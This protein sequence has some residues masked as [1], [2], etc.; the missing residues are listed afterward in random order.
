MQR[1]KIAVITGT[2]AEY[3]LFKPILKSVVEHSALKL[4]LIVTGMHV[5]EDFGYT[6]KEIEKD[7]F[8]IDAVLDTL[9]QEDTCSAMA[10]YIAKCIS[11]FSEEL[12]R[13]KPDILLLLGDRGEMLA[14]AIAATCMNVLIAHI[15]G[16]EVSGSVDEPFR[17]AITKLA[18]L[19]LVATEESAKRVISMGEKPSKV[20]VVGAPGL[21]D[22]FDNLMDPEKLAEKFSL[23]LKKPIILVVQHPVVTE[24]DDAPQQI[25]ETLDTIVELEHQVMLIYPNADSGGRR[26]L[27]VIKNYE[28][29]PFIRTFK[30]LSRNEFLSIMRIANVMVGNSSSGIIEA[31]S[32]CLPVINIGS[33]QKGRQRAENVIDVG[34]NKTEIK[35]A[36]LKALFDK[37]FLDKVKKCRNPYGDGHATRRILKLLTETEISSD[38]LCK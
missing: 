11:E 8:N 10:K 6:I 26:M 17:H 14:G 16:G 1:R 38:M 2:R 9:N 20:F 37:E 29:H 4:H 28:K 30:S 25:K 7:G 24:A 31:S 22:I 13:A 35:A 23:D 32:F 19:H 18:N 3:G 33:R 15:H 12:E 34:Y 27:A 21:D 36:I 5:S